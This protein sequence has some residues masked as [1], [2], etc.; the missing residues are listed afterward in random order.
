MKI[1]GYYP[2]TIIAAVVA[3]LAVVTNVPGSPLTGEQ[4]AWFVTVLS[5]VAVAAEA[6]TVRP[7]TVSTVVGAVRTTIAAV[8][9]FGLPISDELSGAIVSAVAMVFGLLTHAVGT[10]AIEPDPHI[11]QHESDGALS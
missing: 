7:R 1:F 4:A 2:A 11:I 9:L 8:V 5:A 10:P 3:V 6:W